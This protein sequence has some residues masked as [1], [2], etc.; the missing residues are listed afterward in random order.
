MMEQNGDGECAV[1]T[2]DGRSRKTNLEEERKKNLEEERNSITPTISHVSPFLLGHCP[3]GDGP[4]CRLL[5]R[6]RR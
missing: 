4:C 3:V 6:S 1:A 2:S 5:P